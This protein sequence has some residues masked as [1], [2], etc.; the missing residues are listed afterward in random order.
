[1]KRR[2]LVPLACAIATAASGLVAPTAAVAASLTPTVGPVVQVSQN[3]S[4][5]NAEVEQATDPT[6]NTYVYEVWMGCGGILF[7]RSKDGGR[8]FDPPI[9]VPGSTGNTRNAWD[10][11]VVV[12]SDGVVYAAFMRAK[13]ADWYPVVAVSFDH[14]AT[15]PQV[16]YLQ[17]PDHKNWGD[18]DFIAVDPSHPNVVYVTYD[19]GPNRTSV[20]YL[21]AANGSCGF[22]TGDL[23]VVLQKSTDHGATWSSQVHVSPGFPASGGDSAPIFVEPNGR[24]DVLYQGYKI[25][26]TTTYAMDPGH[27]FYTSSTD[28]GSTWSHPVEIGPDTL[29]FSMSLSEWWIDGA[30]AV[31]AGGNLYASWDSQ[32][33]AGKDTGWLSYSTNHGTTWSAPIQVTDSANVAHI[34]EVT[35]GPTG[36]VYVSWLSTASPTTG[37]PT[38]GYS[39]Y[40][41]PFSI[42]SGWLT[43]P[44]K[45]SGTTYGDP[46]TWPGDTT[47]LS[48]LASGQVVLSWG[49]GVPTGSGI[50]SQIFSTVVTF[51]H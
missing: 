48:T 46:N 45:V 26:N 11:A 4:G 31:D 23:N 42:A 24:I 10:P 38:S 47:G 41:Q 37:Q 21:C 32:D 25:T 13:D 44:I 19:Y 5:Q 29:S 28:G 9:S 18:R 15:F 14:G 1:M 17:P 22:A 33:P 6:S 27:E 7:S 34:M 2:W 8:S 43:T 35:A 36:T 39:E 49:S 30:L 40:L 12:G 50:R 16:S 51:Q 3:C 20:T